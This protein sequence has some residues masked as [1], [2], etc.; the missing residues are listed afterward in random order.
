MSE[1]KED[2]LSFEQALDALRLKEEELKRLVSEGEIRAFR[3]GDTM[4]LRRADVDNLRTEL[5]GG[6][7]VDLGENA[8]ELVFED[9]GELQAGMA[10]EEITEVETIVD[11]PAAEAAETVIE[12]E[13]EPEPEP[14]PVDEGIPEGVFPLALSVLAA[15]VLLLALPIVISISRGETGGAAEALAGLLK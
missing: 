7:V 2:Y 3:Q 12:D 8:P 15:A 14:E 10:T 5:S 4:R 11:E 9:E 13:P 1:N 6:E